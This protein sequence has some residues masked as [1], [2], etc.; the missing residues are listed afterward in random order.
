MRDG[1]KERQEGACSAGAV[2]AVPCSR[3]SRSSREENH[4]PEKQARA[5][6]DTLWP[7]QG[8]LSGRGAG[9][10]LPAGAA[11][12]ESQHR[13]PDAIVS[14]SVSPKDN[15]SLQSLARAVCVAAFRLVR[16]LSYR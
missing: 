11:A 13:V 8:R 10:R 9:A 6:P 7:L 2:Q 16:E 4:P 14:A 3:S 15:E 12:G 5:L 1:G